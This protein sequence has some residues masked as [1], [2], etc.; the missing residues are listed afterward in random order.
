MRFSPIYKDQK[1]NI[2]RLSVRMCPRISII[3]R[4]KEKI[5]RWLE[6]TPNFYYC[7][8]FYPILADTLSVCVG[9]IVRL[10]VFRHL[11][12][13]ASNISNKD[14]LQQIYT[15]CMFHFSFSLK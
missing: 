4:V 7:T 3:L 10:S 2:C 14:F 9:L 15:H 1:K 12:H 6:S 13:Y 5:I 11:N 8:I